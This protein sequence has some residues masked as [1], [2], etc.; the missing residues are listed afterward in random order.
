MYLGS[1]VTAYAHFVMVPV[2]LLLQVLQASAPL[3]ASASG[4][5]EY[6]P[7]LGRLVS[8]FLS[9]MA[10]DDSRSAHIGKTIYLLVA[11]ERWL[12]LTQHSSAGAK[13]SLHWLLIHGQPE[14][15]DCTL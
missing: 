3:I 10:M 2:N 12:N 13:I 7:A 8:D 9:L 6:M 5:P 14:K 1:D 4:E 11:T 15:V